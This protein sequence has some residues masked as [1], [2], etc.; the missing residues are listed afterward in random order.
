M[1][2]STTA[3]KLDGRRERTEQTRQRILAAARDLMLAGNLQPTTTDIARHAGITTRTLF[4]HFAEAESL[5]Q[6]MI[7]AAES[8][9]EAIMD[10]PFPESIAIPQQW[11]LQ[12]NHIIDRRSRIYEHLL[13]IYISPLFYQ[14]RSIQDQSSTPSK[15]AA[16]RRK[17]L[18][19]VLP[20]ALRQDKALFEAI[21]ATL[22]IEFW[23][24]LR[25]SQK[26]SAKQARKTVEIAIDRL[27]GYGVK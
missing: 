14:Q 11:R 3:K 13:P 25:Q 15:P 12:L 2:D 20:K 1:A 19:Q 22:G 27:T 7:Q 10:E 24:S 17:R 6:Q 8:S 4:R 26:L 16:R 23:I 5:H 9:V 21:D 18:N